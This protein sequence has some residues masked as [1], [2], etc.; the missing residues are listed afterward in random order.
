MLALHFRNILFWHLQTFYYTETLCNWRFNFCCTISIALLANVSFSLNMFYSQN[1]YMIDTVVKVG[2]GLKDVNNLYKPFPAYIQ[3]FNRRTCHGFQIK[4]VD[5]FANLNTYTLILYIVW[6]SL[7]KVC[8]HDKKWKM[9]KKMKKKR[10]NKNENWK[11]KW[12]V[13][14]LCM[15]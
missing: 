10:R 14:R 2:I 5:I 13:N 9:K 4:Y 1:T 6:W 7:S 8:F 11:L 3:I 15:N 12:D